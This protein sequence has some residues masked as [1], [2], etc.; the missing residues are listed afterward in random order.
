MNTQTLSSIMKNFAA[1]LT[2]CSVI[3]LVVLIFYPQGSLAHNPN[4]SFLDFRINDERISI[5]LTFAITELAKVIKLDSNNDMVI[6]WKEV[7]DNHKNINSYLH[8]NLQ[9]EINENACSFYTRVLSEY[10]HSEGSYVKVNLDL[11]CASLSS[12]I[13][14]VT[15]NYN[16]F[17]SAD[18]QH[19]CILSLAVGEKS[20]VNIIS[21]QTHRQSFKLNKDNGAFFN[22]LR[23]GIWHIWIG[24]D[25]ILFLLS[26]LIPAVLE[27]KNNTWQSCDSLK[28]ISKN[29]F[30][31]VSAFTLAHSLTLT[32]AGLRFVS[33][34]ESFIEPTI[35]LSIAIVALNNIFL[36][37]PERKTYLLAFGFGLIHGFGFASVLNELDLS[38][39]SLVTALLSFNLGVEIGQLAIVSIFLPIAFYFR[40]SIFYK[41]YFKITASWTILII[42]IYWFVERIS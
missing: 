15:I 21:P 35:A 4:E 20:Q 17:F 7:I 5:E 32:L 9:F 11:N 3:S 31:I 1:K 16:L 6:S 34:S 39:N 23:E 26:L 42:A 36:I 30:F 33:L 8:E 10:Q 24:Y 22:F 12:R 14:E 19:L 2:L 40:N 28:K 18:P 29:V 25:H 38:Q 37:F 41:K 27:R 13:Q